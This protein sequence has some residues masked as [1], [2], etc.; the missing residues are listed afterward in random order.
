M[1]NSVC[2]HTYTPLSVERDSPSTQ[3]GIAQVDSRSINLIGSQETK[4]CLIKE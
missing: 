3:S 1:Q 4:N 2:T